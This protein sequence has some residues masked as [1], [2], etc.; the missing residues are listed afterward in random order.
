MSTSTTTNAAAAAV[1][2]LPFQSPSQVAEHLSVNPAVVSAATLVGTWTNVDTA[3]RDLV[4]VVITGAGTSINVNPYGACSPAPCNW[5]VEPAIAYAASVST[6]PAVA[7][8]TTFKFS[9]AVVVVTGHIL[10][11]QLIVETFTEFTDGSGRSN[12][13][14]SNTMAK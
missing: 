2:Q 9:F 3:T 11:K 5:G 1:P 10:G 14:S 8:T 6:T 13:Y 7:F 12:Y 4:K